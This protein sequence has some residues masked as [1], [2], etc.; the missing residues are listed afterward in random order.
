MEAPVYEVFAEGI[1][2]ERCVRDYEFSMS[3]GHSHQR[4][5]IYFLVKGERY[6]F[7]DTQTY[8]VKEG[9]VVLINQNQVHKT[10]AVG[11]QAPY[12]DR[13]LVQLDDRRLAEFLRPY[14]IKPSDFFEKYNGVI[15]LN[16]QSADALRRLLDAVADEISGK[17]YGYEAM[18]YGRIAE[19][20]LLL[21]RQLLHSPLPPVKRAKKTAKHKKVDEVA[22]YL[23]VHYDRPEPLPDLAARFYVN[24]CYLSRIFKEVTG[25][26]IGEY[27]HLRRIAE[28]Q[29]LL[30]ATALS[31]TEVA[32]LVGYES[33]TY[34][35]RVFQKQVGASPL[36]FRKE[37]RKAGQLPG[38]PAAQIL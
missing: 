32:A 31:V 26:T 4:Y 35:E 7:I 18:A 38:V 28:A 17:E 34:F 14:R 11:S 3:A 29:R 33:I 25:V 30:G 13:I 24:K 8:L 27:V 22:G 16:P 23:S 20:I 6:Y 5:E 21:Q 9:S 37:C 19:F 12:H 1:S 36:A 15:E 2:L 10:G